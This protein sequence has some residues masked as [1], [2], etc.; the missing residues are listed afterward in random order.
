MVYIK[1]LKAKGHARREQCCIF[2]YY[3]LQLMSVGLLSLKINEKL[4]HQKC[5]TLFWSWM[6]FMD[7]G[8]MGRILLLCHKN[9]WHDL[10][11]NLSL[12]L[13]KQKQRSASFCHKSRH[14]FLWQTNRTRLLC[15]EN[16]NLRVLSSSEWPKVCF[17]L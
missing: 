17:S 10:W 6:L 1:R 3:F 7:I 16:A 4:I 12:L 2:N 5:T 9:K 13:K 14:L 8:H 11:H 15:S